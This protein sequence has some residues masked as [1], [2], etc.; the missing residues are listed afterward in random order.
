[1][2]RTRKRINRGISSFLLRLNCHVVKYPDFDD[3]LKRLFENNGVHLSL[4][5]CDLFINTPQGA[6]ET[7]IANP[8]CHVYPIH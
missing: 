2:E 4:I 6:L 1:M 3:K 5:G 7:F 8:C